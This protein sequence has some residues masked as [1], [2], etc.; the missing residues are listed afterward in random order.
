MLLLP[1]DFGFGLWR[2]HTM[3]RQ[4]LQSLYFYWL[5]STH[6]FGLP[7]K[8]AHSIP[9]PLDFD[10]HSVKRPLVL[11]KTNRIGDTKGHFTHKPRT[12][13][14]RLWEPKRKCPKTVPTH[15][16]NHVAWS[17]TLKCGV[18]SY[19][20]ISSTKHYLNEFLFMPVLTHDKIE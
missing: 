14:M 8:F 10:N 15:F 13:T 17:R 11:S 2:L 1:L 4:R 5:F 9:C 12:M 3:P 6:F 18:K 19:M 16:Q 7:T 20:T